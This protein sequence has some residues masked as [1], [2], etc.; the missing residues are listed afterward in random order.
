MKTLYGDRF[1]ALTEEDSQ[2]AFSEYVTDAQRR[3][4]HDLHF[5]DEPRQLRFDEDVKMVDG[6]VQVGG[7]IAVMSINE[8]L[9]QALMAKNPDLE[10]AVQESSPLRGT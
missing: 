5:P 7:Q 8:H 3:L 9:L 2:R 10:F 4:E 6:R 1:A